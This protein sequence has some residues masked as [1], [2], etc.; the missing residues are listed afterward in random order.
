MSRKR[1]MAF[2]I[3]VSVFL[4][5]A[6]TVSLF[7]SKPVRTPSAVLPTVTLPGPGTT[8][9]GPYLEDVKKLEITTDNV[10]AVIEKLERPAS[11]SQGVFL[12]TYLEQGKVSYQVMVWAKNKVF[13]TSSSR[14]GGDRVLN[15]IVTEDYLYI[16][17]DNGPEYR[18][19]KLGQ[20]NPEQVA[21]EYQKIPTYEDILL[22]DRE[23]ILEAGYADYEGEPCIH[24]KAKTGLLGYTYEYY[25]SARTGLLVRAETYDG[26]KLIHSTTAGSPNLSEPSD[27]MFRLPDGSSAL[28]S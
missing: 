8:P 6:I 22:L 26:E 2:S 28:T 12:D 18:R 19:L 25:V 11:Y 14:L 4:L 24:V 16:W 23:D 27:D 7:F 13:K 5:L 3:S 10:Q 20:G 17:Y 21:D 9:S 1:M 15:T